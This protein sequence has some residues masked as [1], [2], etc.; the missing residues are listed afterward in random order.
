MNLLGLVMPY[1]I[2]VPLRV[3]YDAISKLSFGRG[4][5]VFFCLLFV[6]IQRVF[7]FWDKTHGLA[8]F[9]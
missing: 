2:Q 1:P 9:G 4:G 6:S 8:K 5:G 7:I 3:L